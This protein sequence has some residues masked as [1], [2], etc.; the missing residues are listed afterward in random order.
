[1]APRRQYNQQVDRKKLEDNSVQP[2]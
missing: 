1:M 2:I